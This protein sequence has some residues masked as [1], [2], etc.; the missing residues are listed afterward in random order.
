[1]TQHK[2]DYNS[3]SDSELRRY[4]L[5]HREDQAAFHAYMDR[6]H[7]RPNRQTISPD[8]PEWQQKIISSLNI[9]IRF[10]L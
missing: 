9:A 5:E 3:M 6:R 8:D 7:A 2:I 10:E 1:M 4:F